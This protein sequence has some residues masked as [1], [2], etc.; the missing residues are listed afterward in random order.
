LT[1]INRPLYVKKMHSSRLKEFDYNINNNF[2]EL[3]ELKEIISLSDNQILR[4]IRD[5]TKQELNKD[6]IEYLIKLKNKFEIFMES[7]TIN[8][9]SPLYKKVKEMI[10][11]EK[12]KNNN[13]V[14]KIYDNLNINP[15]INQLQKIQDK[16][17]R[18]SYVEQYLVIVMDNTQQYDYLYHNGVYINGEKY[19]RLSCSA[20][21]ARV[22][23][24]IFC[25]ESILEE[26]DRRLNNGRDMNKKFSPS[27][28][29]AYYGLYGSSTK[30]VTEPK[31]IVIKDFE[32]ITS[33]DANFVIENG[34]KVDD[35]VNVRHLENVKID[36]TDGMGLISPKMSEIWSKDLGL[37][38]IPSSFVIRQSFIKG[39]LCTFPIHQFCEDKNN[40]N[41]IVDTIYKDENGEYI[42]ADLRDYDVILTE[43]QFKLWDSYNS[44]DEYIDN[45]HKNNLKWGVTLI[46]P[47]ECK[48]M[49]KLNYQFIQTLNLK[50][51]DVL[52]LCEQF[53]EW[54]EKVSYDNPYYMML[55][56]LGVNNDEN[57]IKKFLNSSDNYW[58]KSLIINNNVKNDKY[59][60]TKVRELIKTKIENGC[61][62]DIY[63]DGNF[64]FII[65]DPYGFMQHVCG[66]EVTGL[67]K[68][69]MS[70]SNYWNERNVKIVDGMRSPLTYRSEHVALSFQKD[71]ETEKWYRYIKNGII[72]N[73]YGH[74]C[75]NL[76]G[77]DNDGD[78][79]ATTNNRTMIKCS[80]KDELP[81]V[82]E[83]PKPK[84]I[85]FTKDDLY[86]SDVFS[87]GSIIGSLTNKGS[88]G[89]ALLPLIGDKY[90]ENDARYKLVKSRLQQCC[91]AQSAQI[92]K[93]KIGK[94]V[95]G[96]PDVWIKRNKLKT[97]KSGKIIDKHRN[98]KEF[99][100]ETL[101]DV[102]PYFFRYIY[103]DTKKKYKE[104][105]EEYNKTCKHKFNI[106]FDE[107]LTKQ[108]KTSDEQCFIDQ[109][110]KYCPVIISDSSMNLVCKYIEGID[111]GIANNTKINA[112]EEV[113]KD[114]KK[115]DI[116]YLDYY[117]NI[118]D[119][120]KEI[121]ALNRITLETEHNSDV[122]KDKEV[123]N[124]FLL[125]CGQIDIVVNC[126]VDFY[127][128]NNTKMNKDFLWKIFGKY[129]YKNIKNNT[130]SK[131][132]F[133]VKDD[134]GDLTYLGYK[135]KLQEIK[136]N[137]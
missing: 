92:D 10:L 11:N 126:L 6:K 36:R 8:Y 86:Q 114:Y 41:Y 72:L 69:G 108:R 123:I 133:P 117:D 135:Y 48:R 44:I 102:Y 7:F 113:F 93:A 3:K 79:I 130:E 75:F 99:Y 97:N 106:S 64:Q 137:E 58:L 20:S 115:K 40:G 120:L 18:S 90:G 21:Q 23:T 66:H 22:S 96:I 29:N 56:L 77:S 34:W 17:Y 132:L 101:L 129:I 116:E 100:N 55:F 1:N 76:A 30:L 47:K 98:R 71:K 37:D 110:Y 9:K 70:Y 12:Y 119:K 26:V 89:Y 112:T 127:Y 105:V 52:N 95:K 107:L 28:Y 53:V 78:E 59:V 13:L 136:M 19:V 31:F 45:C 87:F 5:I 84:K 42:K 134:N 62:G 121:I 88:N 49:L 128:I 104:Y 16:I 74:E 118:S 68:E 51:E 57:K 46:A 63:V 109:F 122:L 80:Y 33:F 67:L 43:S 27:K 82:Y 24:V 131:I 60:R 124:E 54:I 32:N 4:T 25:N 39:L 15:Y 94:E 103:K 81:V 2:N 61:K 35:T 38:Y 111:F 65:S 91:K 125:I 83:A 85:L 73:Y 50:K 14:K